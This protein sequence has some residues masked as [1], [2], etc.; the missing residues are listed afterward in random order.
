MKKLLP[1]LPLFLVLFSTAAHADVYTKSQGMNGMGTSEMWVSGKKQR[2]VV[3]SPLAQGMM[4]DQISITRVDKGVEWD[5]DMELKAYQEKPIPIPYKEGS[6]ES[7]TPEEQK[8]MEAYKK[9]MDKVPDAVANDP[10]AQSKK[11]GERTIAGFQAEGYGPSCPQQNS[12]IGAI[13]LASDKDPKAAKIQK[14]ISA[15]EKAKVDSQ[16]SLYPAKEREELIKSMTLIGSALAQ[17]MTGMPYA[18]NLPERLALAMSQAGQDEN[19]NAV[20]NMLFEM[21]QA[22][23]VKA[24][25]ALFELP[26]GFTKVDDL[27]GMRSQNIMSKMSNGDFKLS[28]MMNN[29]SATA[30]QMGMPAGDA[31]APSAEDMQQADQFGQGIAQAVQ[32]EARL[33]GALPPA[34]A[35][36]SRA[37]VMQQPLQQ[38]AQ[39]PAA[40]MPPEDPGM[41]AV[42]QASASSRPEAWQN[43]LY[44]QGPAQ[45]P[46]PMQQPQAYPNAGYPQQY[47]AQQGAYPQQQGYANGG[48]PQQQGPYPPRRPNQTGN[49]LQQAGQVLGQIQNIASQFSG[50]GGGFQGQMPNPFDGSTQD[51]GQQDGQYEGDTSGDYQEQ[52]EDQQSEDAPTE[53]E[54]RQ[55]YDTLGRYMNGGN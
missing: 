38:L 48:Y 52:Y 43:G 42:R 25:P 14:E 36:N 12:M 44:D 45:G 17:G 37:S 47:P 16:Y 33:Q 8:E 27:M 31:E 39:A 23:T 29:M 55:A 19:G 40:A 5:I 20:E 51:Y 41:K 24:D 21:Q 4:G 28:D 18:K 15:F 53:D 2:L 50:G 10:C 13:W 11:V 46:M 35:S 26:E 22:D 30:K 54:A 3:S 32:Q 49:T 1:V 6:D 7:L 9:Q 34:Q